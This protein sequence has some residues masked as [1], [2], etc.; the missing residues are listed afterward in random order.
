MAVDETESVVVTD[1]QSDQE[2]TMGVG[3]I[4]GSPQQW[5]ESRFRTRL[6][7]GARLLALAVA[8]IAGVGAV[9][10]AIGW[11]LL[12][13]TI[14]PTAYLLLVHPQSESARLR[15]CLLG[16]ACATAS[17]LVCLAAFGLWHHPSAIE[18]HRDNWR[19]I[20][21]QTLAVGMT[22]LLL[23]LLNANHPPAASTALLIASG[24]AR[25]GPPL[26]GMLTGLVL[27]FVG[28]AV[29]SR[30]SAPPASVGDG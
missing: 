11:V 15:C 12:T 5:E 24:L 21:A 14:G 28:V 2:I 26:Y 20:A 7:S 18:L 23:V 19:Q 9:G 10:Q 25:P 30:F 6:R 1:G 16:H 13:T 27:L 4:R 8:L 22:I 17:G 29:V 3:R